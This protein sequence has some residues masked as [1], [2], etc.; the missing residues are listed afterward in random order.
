MVLRL[1]TLLVNAGDT[2][3]VL[4][5]NTVVGLLSKE[6]SCPVPVLRRNTVVGLLSKEDPCLN[7]AATSYGIDVTLSDTADIGGCPTPPSQAMEAMIAG[8]DTGS[9]RVDLR[10]LLAEHTDLFAWSEM[11]LGYTDK[12]HNWGYSLL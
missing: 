8:C 7:R 3:T 4:R 1:T 10:H 2:A 6:D 12:V 11:D 9:Q 5:R